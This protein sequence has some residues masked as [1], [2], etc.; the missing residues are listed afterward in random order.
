MDSVDF[1]RIFKIDHKNVISLLE[2]F[3]PFVIGVRVQ[4]GERVF[5]TLTLGKGDLASGPVNERVVMN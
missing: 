2:L 5:G 4:E 3:I 1:D